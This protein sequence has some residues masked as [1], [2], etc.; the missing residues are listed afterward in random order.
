[1]QNVKGKTVKGGNRPAAIRCEDFLWMR[2]MSSLQQGL[3]SD[4]DQ[5]AA[6][7]IMKNSIGTAEKNGYQNQ[8]TI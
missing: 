3:L 4:Y 8:Q 2:T 7:A 5:E 1:M 6:L